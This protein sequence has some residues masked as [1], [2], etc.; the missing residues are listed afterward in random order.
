MTSL[1]K[2]N[3]FTLV[4]RIAGK[5][6]LKNKWIYK[7]K[8]E[9]GKT[10]PTYNASHTDGKT[11]RFVV[12]GKENLVYNLKKSLYGLKQAPMQWYKKFH[13]FMLGQEFEKTLV[14]HCV[15][16]KVLKDTSFI[17]LLLYVD[18][19]LLV[20]DNVK[21]INDLKNDLSRV[22][23]MKD[24][25]EA[26]HILGMQIRRERANRCLSLSQEQYILKVLKRFNMDD[27][28][29]VSC[30]LNVQ[31]KLGSKN[32]PPSQ[33][34]IEYM[35]KVPYASA[36]GSLI[37]AMICTRADI[38]L[39][40]DVV[41]EAYT[42]VDMAEDV[43]SKRSTSG[44]IFTFGGGA[45][46]WQSKLKKCVALSTTEEEYIAITECCKELLWMKRIF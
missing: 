14:Y 46:S 11:T 45:V 35:S 10:E 13:S 5:K 36:V 31:V 29:A 42:D 19:M 16:K 9:E 28:K 2:N 8:F 22:F 26:K 17:I 24:L 7:L 3:T 18:D 34:D 25:G 43:D 23:E 12:K 38:G 41:L 30:P 39:G 33:Q 37:Y 21:K 6:V 40:K 32:C 27:A 15:Y 1:Y 4:K 44:Y 20:G